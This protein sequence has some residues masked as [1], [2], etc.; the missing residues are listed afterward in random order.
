MNGDLRYGSRDVLD[1]T[2]KDIAT[3]KPLFYFESL[4][5]SEMDT[6]AA[7]VYAKG[8]RGN[9]QLIAWTGS[10]TIT[11]NCTDALISPKSFALFSGKR[12]QK[13]TKL[14]HKK[15]ALK[16]MPTSGSGVTTPPT[17]AGTY[18]ELGMMNG[19]AK[20]GATVDT[21]HPMFVYKGEANGVTVSTDS[22][23]G[24]DIEF[25][26]ATTTGT[27]TT[28]TYDVTAFASGTPNT[29]EKLFFF[30]SDVTEG[31]IIIVDY[32]YSEKVTE[33]VIA[34]DSF[35]DTFLVEGLTLFRDENGYDH[36]AH[37]SIPKAKLA[38]DFKISFKPD[39]D[40]ATFAFTLNALKPIDSTDMVLMDIEDDYIDKTY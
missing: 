28:K 15:E 12:S 13:L 36:I 17:G 19:E 30:S 24:A 22:T 26:K 37:L 16:A 34:S 1:F 35:P 10:R 29:S 21:T 7:T 40:P 31:D 18:V 25:T 14:V 2:F 38:S 39:G 9:P 20:Y 8:G 11:F 27:V 5:T 23:T 33:I 3:R 6:K 32:Y 4:K